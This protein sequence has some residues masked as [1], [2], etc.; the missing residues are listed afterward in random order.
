ML[1]EVVV[2]TFSVGAT[3]VG[4][5]LIIAAFRV[6]RGSND[7]YNMVRRVTKGFRS[8]MFGDVRQ[9]EGDNSVLYRRGIAYVVERDGTVRFEAQAKINQESIRDTS[10]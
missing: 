8:T 1:Y 5:M 9:P 3:V 6:W 2:A 10:V 4:A 7:A